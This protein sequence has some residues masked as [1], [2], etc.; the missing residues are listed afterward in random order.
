MVIEV[1]VFILL[2][3][4]SAFVSSA[5][6]SYIYSSRIKKEIETRKSVSESG[7]DLNLNGYTQ[8]FIYSVS[9]LGVILHFAIITY[10]AVNL[11]RYFNYQISFKL[12]LIVASFLFIME[13]FPKFIA[14]EFPEKIYRISYK[15]VRGLSFLFSPVISLAQRISRAVI[16]NSEI[17]FSRQTMLF[18]KEDIH[19]LVEESE[20]AGKV[21]KVDSNYIKKVLDLTDQKVYEAMRPR[22]EIVG[23]EISSSIPAVLE[24]FISSGY[25]KLPVYEDNLDNIKGV[26]Y[27]YDLYKKPASMNEI[28]RE[29]I[30]VPETKKSIDMLYDFLNKGLS[31]A[32]VVDEFGGTSGLVTMEDIIE[33]LFGEIKDEYDTEDDILLQSRD[34][35]FIVSGKVEIDYINEKYNLDFPE[36]D[37]ET[38]AGFIISQ[39]GRIPENGEIIKID[40]YSIKILRSSATKVEMIKISID[41]EAAASAT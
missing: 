33:E 9:I 20:E 12:L 1:V 21:D 36:G 14:T 30:F 5:E 32:I 10:L 26:V 3:L 39:L 38:V 2:V 23:V 4:L 16:K 6:I 28:M 40:K 31:I 22:T 19:T 17:S 13:I 37:Y 34:N 25:S 29:I 11:F 41:N 18:D 27:N 15:V 35:S 7:T 8:E 24:E